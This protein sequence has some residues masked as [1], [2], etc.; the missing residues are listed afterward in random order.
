MLANRAV[1]VECSRTRDGEKRSETDT[2]VQTSSMTFF[3]LW[4]MQRS[5]FMWSPWQL[6]GFLIGGKWNWNCSRSGWWD[7]PLALDLKM[8]TWLQTFLPRLIED[9]DREAEEEA[10]KSVC[11]YLCECHPCKSSWDGH[12]GCIYRTLLFPTI[13]PLNVLL[14]VCFELLAFQFECVGDQAGLRCPWLGTQ[15]DFF[16]NLKLLQFS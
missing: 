14:V 9:G 8:R 13:H 6:D 11:L 16:G 12:L 1:E 15:A 5:D 4:V 3:I 7:R 10:N 2:D